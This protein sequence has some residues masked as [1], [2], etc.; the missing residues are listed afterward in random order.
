MQV[1]KWSGG[2]KWRCALLPY[3]R[4]VLTT[5]TLWEAMQIIL[6]AMKATSSGQN[7][8]N[9]V[10]LH[11]AVK[12][13]QSDIMYLSLS[14]IL[15]INFAYTIFPEKQRRFLW[16]FTALHVSWILGHDRRHQLIRCFLIIIFIAL[17]QT[18]YFYKDLSID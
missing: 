3:T 12:C 17:N 18:E 16:G 10:F 13:Y 5:N 15:F 4:R 6:D 9:R 11:C 14:K 1:D 2:L 8:H 7:V